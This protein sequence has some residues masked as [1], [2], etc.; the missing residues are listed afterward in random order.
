MQLRGL[1]I[2]LLVVLAALAGAPRAASAAPANAAPA[3]SERIDIGHTLFWAA[4]GKAHTPAGQVIVVNTPLEHAFWSAADPRTGAGMGS[5]WYSI[6]SGVVPPD[7]PNPDGRMP[8]YG[9]PTPLQME[10]GSYEVE[11]VV[12]FTP[13]GPCAAPIPGCEASDAD[14]PGK[15]AVLLGGQLEV[16][17]IMRGVLRDGSYVTRHATMFVGAPGTHSPPDAF[18]GV[19][20][21]IDGGM[22]FSVNDT[23]RDGKLVEGK[24]GTDK[25]SGRGAEEPLG[26]GIAHFV[27]LRNTPLLAHFRGKPFQPNGP[28]DVRSVDEWYD[29]QS[30]LLTFTSH[31]GQSADDATFVGPHD[32]AYAPRGVSPV[33]PVP[34]SGPL[35]FI[36][37]K[38]TYGRIPG[39][40][41]AV[42]PDN[43][44]FNFYGVVWTKEGGKSMT[45]NEQMGTAYPFNVKT[46]EIHGGG[47]Y[48]IKDESGK[49]TEVGV[50]STLSVQNF[51][52][53]GQNFAPQLTA[54]DQYRDPGPPLNTM[55]P[56]ANEQPTIRDAGQ[57]GIGAVYAHTYHAGVDPMS[58]SGFNHGGLI[59]FTAEMRGVSLKDGKST[60]RTT[61]VYESC[62][63][64]QPPIWAY[65]GAKVPDIDG[66]AYMVSRTVNSI[67]R[68]VPAH[69]GLPPGEGM[70]GQV[71]LHNS[72]LYAHFVGKPFN[73]DDD[74]YLNMRTISDWRLAHTV[75]VASTMP[76]YGDW[77][78]VAGDRHLYPAKL[79]AEAD[80][81]LGITD[82]PVLGLA[83][84]IY[85]PPPS[86]PVKAADAPGGTPAPPGP[87]A[88]AP[89]PSAP[90]PG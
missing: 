31:E 30:A 68:R 41:P 52:S 10:G 60:K 9:R 67:G 76:A 6:T 73:P 83:D 37:L 84:G 34:L 64:G 80:K 62:V 28:L 82:D 61:L 13:W 27:E 35:S 3:S 53:F 14:R 74:A 40:I 47:W 44:W 45:F 75:V 7:H 78:M 65:E 26:E 89:P 19:K 57:N 54:A 12:R 70:T 36:D 2:V 86:P 59:V 55:G 43:W 71:N 39:Q 63:D 51:D 23:Y 24:F 4:Y 72:P 69:Y 16:R 90:N 50:W 17:I 32:A 22:Q 46:G 42:G 21:L 87:A 8:V 33:K 11:R 66:D 1:H 58:T 79:R 18:A 38:K 15:T 49:L 81:T 29:V 88:V 85:C 5:G 25:L 77:P 56:A 20:V 48:F